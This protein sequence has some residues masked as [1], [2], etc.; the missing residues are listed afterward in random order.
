MILR[1]TYMGGRSQTVFDIMV[2]GQKIAEQKL[3]KLE[4]DQKRVPFDVDYKLPKE[5][6]KGRNKI[7]VKF[8]A[9]EAQ[10][11]GSVFGVRILKENK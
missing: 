8:A 9:R 4:R 11:T 10:R 3:E 6:I 5:L 1:I 2:D 7:T